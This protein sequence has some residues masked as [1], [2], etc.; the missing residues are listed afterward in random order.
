MAKNDYSLKQAPDSF[1]YFK[2]IT[3]STG[4]DFSGLANEAQGA[5]SGILM[6]A[7]GTLAITNRYGHTVS[8]TLPAGFHQVEAVAILAATNVDVICYW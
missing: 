8:D 4:N 1:V 7:A 3:A 2:R 6:T 5:C